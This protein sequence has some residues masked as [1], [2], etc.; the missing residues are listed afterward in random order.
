MGKISCAVLRRYLKNTM[1]V[2]LDGSFFFF[3]LITE[4]TNKAGFT[5]KA[6]SI[7]IDKVLEAIFKPQFCSPYM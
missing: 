2:A 4:N 5:G 3:F 6:K 1:D 7:M